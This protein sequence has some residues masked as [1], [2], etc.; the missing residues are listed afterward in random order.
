[1]GVYIVYNKLVIT[2]E[3]KKF[4]F[5]LSRDADI[6]I[7]HELLYLSISINS[8]AEK[9]RLDNYYPNVSTETILLST[10]NSKTNEPHKFV[11]NLLDELDLRSSNKHVVL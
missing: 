11:F 10:E 3:S 1:M 8:I 7:E 6:N 9:T 4:C 2:T 5:D